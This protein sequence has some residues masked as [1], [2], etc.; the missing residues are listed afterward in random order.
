NDEKTGQLIPAL[1]NVMVGAYSCCELLSLIKEAG[2]KQAR[3]V[4]GSQE[5]GF[6][7]ITAEKK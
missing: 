2:F 3:V 1:F 4:A 5:I 7:W 6:T